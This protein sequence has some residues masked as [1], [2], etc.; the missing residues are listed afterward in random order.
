MNVAGLTAATTRDELKN[1]L[2][3]DYDV[4]R[5]TALR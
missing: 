1:K 4:S 3:R 5:G 2:W